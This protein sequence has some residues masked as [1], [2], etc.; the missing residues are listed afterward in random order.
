VME[1][2][3]IWYEYRVTQN[4]IVTPHSIEVIDPAPD[5]PGV[6]PSQAMMTLTTCNPKWNDYQ[7]MAVHAV[8]IKTQA[9]SAGPPVALGS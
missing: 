4:E 9:T 1:T 5:Q 3:D 2:R 6:A 7:R 8:L